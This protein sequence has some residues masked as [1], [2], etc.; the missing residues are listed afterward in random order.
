MNIADRILG[1]I[2]LD[3]RI[4]DGVFDILNNDHMEVL[5]EYLKKKDVPDDIIRELSNLVV[6][7]GKYP[8]RQAYNKDGLLVTFPTPAY[9]QRAIQRGTHFEKN[10]VVSKSNLFGGGE[11]A[12]NEPTPSTP[13]TTL[14]Q[15][16]GDNT[17]IKDTGMDDKKSSLP[18]SGTSQPSTVSNQPPN[19]SKQ[20]NLKIEPT[21][22]QSDTPPNISE[23]P[24]PPQPKPVQKTPQEVAAEKEV[25]KQIFNTDDTLPTVPGVG[26][27]GLS[28]ELKVLTKIAIDM[29]LTEAVRFLSKSI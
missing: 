4:S 9:K 17:N 22:K 13:P 10:P 7:K 26:G 14:S 21:Q 3:D 2:C 5:R 24:Q 1:D 15:L 23:P 19:V 25:V 28:E 20:Q 12:P 8:E 18:V 29:N 11:T 16:S 27:S 6:E